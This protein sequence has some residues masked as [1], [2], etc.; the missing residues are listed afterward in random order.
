MSEVRKIT[1][2]V[3]GDAHPFIMRVTELD[4][5]YHTEDEDAMMDIVIPFGADKDQSFRSN[6]KNAKTIEEVKDICESWT[7]V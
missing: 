6:I 5:V 7:N 1:Y 2:E 4:D 3:R